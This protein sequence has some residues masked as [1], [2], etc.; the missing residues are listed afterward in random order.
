MFNYE[1]IDHISPYN[2]EFDKLVFQHVHEIYPTCSNNYANRA[3]S[4][5]KDK[6]T[7]IKQDIY[8]GK[9]GELHCQEFIRKRGI[10]QIETPV[11]LDVYAAKDKKFLSDF[12]TIKGKLLCGI[13]CKSCKNIYR[14][15]L[16][17]L[18]KNLLGYSED[19]YSYVFQV[20]DQLYWDD[21]PN[22]DLEDCDLFVTFFM[23]YLENGDVRIV[24]C[25]NNDLVKKMFVL[26]LKKH[27]WPRWENGKFVGKK[28]IME[29]TCFT[30]NGFPC[31]IREVGDRV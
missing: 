20:E 24:G 26:P 31:G 29:K 10:A 11:D 12:R 21:R 3:Q 17:D 25:M 28:C 7:K 22:L 15:N 16:Y 23:N 8:I 9:I 18:N 19:Q 27:L 13:S 14:G 5:E 6:N 1:I 4:E 2:K 30:K